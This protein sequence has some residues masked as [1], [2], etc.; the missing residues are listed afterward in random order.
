MLG[1][2]SQDN[3]TAGSAP[4]GYIFDVN[5]NDFEAKVMAASMETPVIV[6]FWAPWCGPCKQLMPILEKAVQ[7][8]KGE[9]LLAKVNLDEN[10]ELAQALRVQSV[11]TVYGFFGG[12][13]VDA[14]QGMQPESAI[15]AFVDKLVQAARANKPEAI[16]IP[17][18]LKVAAEA[19]AN[20][21]LPMAQGLYMQILQQ[22]ENNAA[23]YTGLIRTFIAANVLDQAES[24][25]ENVPDSMAKSA[26]LEAARTA[27]DLA[28]K[29]SGVDISALNKAVE[30][31][32]KDQQVRIDLA[33][34]QFAV[35]QKAEAIET[36]LESIDMDR[37]WNED[38]ARKSLLQFFEALGHSDPLTVDGRKKLST[39]LFS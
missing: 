3:E 31:N 14:F 30:A 7:A 28:K 33:E 15:N 22:D 25:I 5:A 38:A 18:T 20:N 24:M 4:A 17:D 39:I 35:G 23:A 8:A 2:G 34:G 10:P 36:L 1:F 9:V 37:N 19:L 27:L 21:D 12:R 29:A 13:P 32:P 11:P 26:E 6:D 16:D